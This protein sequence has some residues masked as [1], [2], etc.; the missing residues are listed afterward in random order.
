MTDKKNNWKPMV[1]GIFVSIGILLLTLGIYFI[2]KRQQLFNNT[3]KISGVFRDISGLQVGNN[4]RFSGINIGVV[5]N[6]EIVTDTTVLVDFIMDIGVK[7]FIKADSKAI[8]GNDGLMGNKIVTILPGSAGKAEIAE[9]AF[10]K[11]VAP[12]SFDEILSNLKV[13][14]DNSAR[15]SQD[16]TDIVHN[17]RSGKGTIGKLFMDSTFANNIDKS[18][19]NI[20]KGTAGFSK[21]MDAA[22]NSILLKGFLK[23]KD[24]KKE[25]KSK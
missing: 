3:F 7:K 10:V 25:E 11:T 23:K 6:I 4:V 19:V 22:S 1:L 14:T 12:I 9:N 18:I 2:G 20:K 17:I 13:T 8:V 15:I 21:N 5:E 16:L 24:S